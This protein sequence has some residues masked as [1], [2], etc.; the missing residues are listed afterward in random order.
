MVICSSCTVSILVKQKRIRCSSA[1]CSN[2]YHQECV[3]FNETSISRAKWTC[4][5]CSKHSS[6][7]EDDSNGLTKKNS[8]VPAN[9]SPNASI[10]ITNSFQEMVLDE[11]R[12]LRSEINK[13]FAEQHLCLN[14]FDSSLLCLQ[15]DIKELGSK[16]S[17]IRKELDEVTKSVN[18]LSEVHDDQIKINAENTKI[19]SKLAAENNSLKTQLNDI[20]CHL[21]EIEQRNVA[22]RYGI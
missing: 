19:I 7:G 17:E 15:K 18:F 16:F 14:K 20:S 22:K 13:K 21:A 5:T 9:T 4:P 11:I 12:S 6:K 3:K 2:Q 10:S 1:N 8:P